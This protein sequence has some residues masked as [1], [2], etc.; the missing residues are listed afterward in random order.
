M[1]SKLTCQNPDKLIF[2]LDEAI[3]WRETFRKEQKSVV[4]TNGCFDIMH[5]GHAEYL[6]RAR[7]NGDA[8]IIALNSDQSVKA[9]KGKNRPIIDEYNRAY[10]LASLK[11]VDAVVIFNSSRCTKLI[12]QIKPDIYIKGGDYTLD[13]MDKAEKNALL[14][15]GS[16]IKFIPFINGFS[17]TDILAK[18]KNDA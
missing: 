11:V 17:T 1:T 4:F 5:R 18:I 13:T 16:V 9:L 14:D 2:T 8:L 3:E 12:K 15:V 7:C 6:F 10:L